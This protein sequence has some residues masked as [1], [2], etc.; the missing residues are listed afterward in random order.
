MV[1]EPGQEFDAEAFIA[2]EFEHRLGIHD[3]TMQVEAG[4]EPCEGC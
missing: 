3:A 4:G 2:R 1:I